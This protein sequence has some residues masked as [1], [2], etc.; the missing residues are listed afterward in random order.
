MLDMEVGRE[1][2]H[3]C[4][5]RV[6]GH[7]LVYIAWK[8]LPRALWVMIIGKSHS[9]RPKWT[10]TWS[11]VLYHTLKVEETAKCFSLWFLTSFSSGQSVKLLSDFVQKYN[12]LLFNSGMPLKG[13]PCTNQHHQTAGLNAKENNTEF[14]I[15]VKYNNIKSK[16]I[17]DFKLVPM[18]MLKS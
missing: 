18:A 10:S 1:L 8:H 16:Q 9:Y 11:D 15:V 7:M 5:Q 2:C 12:I 3:W 13:N 17:T 14:K 4:S 6:G